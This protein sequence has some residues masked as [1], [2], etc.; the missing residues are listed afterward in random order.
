MARP[1]PIAEYLD[2][3]VGPAF[4][5]QGFA[6]SDILAAWPDIVGE[7]LARVSRPQRLEW[8]R[9][10]RG[11]DPQSRPEPGTLVVRIEGAFALEMQHLAPLI[12]ERLNA[13]Y[14]WRCVGR[15]GLRQDR[16]GRGRSAPAAVPAPD[17]ERRAEVREAVAVIADEGLR[18]ALDRL[19][20]AVVAEAGAR[21]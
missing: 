14:G 19:G 15:I 4:A 3:C 21:P 13:H 7:R 5:A 9:R 8:P 11:A 12:V 6:S 20:T 16:V 18:E 1:K 17:P 2:R 10:I